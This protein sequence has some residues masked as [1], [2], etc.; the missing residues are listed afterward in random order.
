MTHKQFKK[1][2]TDRLAELEPI[3]RRPA[4]PAE[5]ALVAEAKGYCYELGLHDFALTLPDNEPVKTPLTAANQLRRCL[6]VLEQPQEPQGEYLTI[7]QAATVANLGER[8]VYR[9][10]ENKEVKYRRVG[11]AIRVLRSDLER[12]ME[13]SESLFD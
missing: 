4:S 13:G 10:V 12:Y 9:L 6:A 11:K 1:W 2:L 5:S 8:T 7:K 3:I